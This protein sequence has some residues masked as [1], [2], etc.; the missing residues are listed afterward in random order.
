MGK[1]EGLLLTWVLKKLFDD[2]VILVQLHPVCLLVVEGLLLLPLGL[3]L[4]LLCFEILIVT[5]GLGLSL[6]LLLISELSLLSNEL[7]PVILFYCLVLGL[8]YLLSLVLTLSKQLIVP[9]LIIRLNYHIFVAFALDSKRL[10][11]GAIPHP[12]ISCVVAVLLL[13]FLHRHR[14][15]E[16]L[17]LRVSFK[18]IS[19][20]YGG[21][22]G[23]EWLL[24]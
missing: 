1:R 15:R 20:G 6:F 9:N 7:V 21:F 8:V 3:L 11:D 12:D 16:S 5:V 10:V 4:D 13:L 2:V 23:L 19:F 22:V 17:H 24:A 18:L 14:H